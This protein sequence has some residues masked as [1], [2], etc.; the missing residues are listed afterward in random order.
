VDRS[1]PG[2]EPKV[3]VNVMAVE[4]HRTLADIA[5]GKLRN[6]PQYQ[7]LPDELLKL[8]HVTLS[9]DGEPTLA[10]NF[11]EVVETVVHVR[12]LGEFPFF[13]IV[14]LTNAAGL[15]LPP[16]RAGLAHL[17]KSDEIWAKLDAGSQEYLNRIARPQGITLEKILSNILLV[18]RQRPVVIQSLFPSI[19][20][21]EPT[22]A[23]IDQYIARLKKLKD[24]GAQ[25]SL[26]QI[27]SATRPNSHAECGHLPLRTL[28][29]IALAVR[30]AT[31]FK[32]EV[33]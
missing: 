16:V 31:G 33:F 22:M 30:H 28:S 10:A 13:K 20:G 23:E 21:D 11:A 29:Q 18:A 27:Y 19:N 14:L 15:D 24:D 2:V 1:R 32:A 12:A 8:R 7:M 25:I 4:L 17:I 6:Y 3:N 9:G 26:V 5:L